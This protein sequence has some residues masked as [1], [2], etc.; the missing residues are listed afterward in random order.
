[1][2]VCKKLREREE[3]RVRREKERRERDSIIWLRL[4]LMR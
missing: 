2:R 3:K 1:M 4:L